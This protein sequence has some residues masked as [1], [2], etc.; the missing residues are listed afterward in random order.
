MNRRFQPNRSGK[1]AAGNVSDCIPETWPEITVGSTEEFQGQERRVIIITTVRSQPELLQ[2]DF[3]HKLG[4]LRNP[5]R[6]NVAITRAKALLIVVGNPNLLSLDSYWREFIRYTIENGG[7]T[8]VRFNLPPEISSGVQKGRGRDCVDQLQDLELCEMEQKFRDMG[9]AL[10]EVESS[11]SD[12]SDLLG[13]FENL[14]LDEISQ[15]EY[16]E[17]Q[18]WGNK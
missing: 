3:T 15:R 1:K 4:F 11:E 7:Y 6:F 9:F 2:H 16:E 18:E 14:E 13:S 8:G 5:K 17:S 12:E 10:D